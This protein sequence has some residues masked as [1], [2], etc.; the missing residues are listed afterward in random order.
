MYFITR[1]RRANGSRV[2]QERPRLASVRLR[3]VARLVFPGLSALTRVDV[4]ELE[5][6]DVELI[7]PTLYCYIG[8]MTSWFN[9]HFAGSSDQASDRRMIYHLY[10]RGIQ[11]C[12]AKIREPTGTL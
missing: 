8:G 4:D 12:R 10:G 1:F 7:L 11:T 5:Y 9:F 3:L 2:P 6:M